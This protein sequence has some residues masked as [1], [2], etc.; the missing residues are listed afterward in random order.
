MDEKYLFKI[1]YN[2]YLNNG[3]FLNNMVIHKDYYFS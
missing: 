3:N 2:R 1:D